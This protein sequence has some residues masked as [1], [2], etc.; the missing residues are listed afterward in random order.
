MKAIQFS[1]TTQQPLLATSFQG[2]PNSDVSY[3]YI[4]GST[5]RGA[6]IG[7]YLK[8]HQISDLDAAHDADEV[9][10][11]FFDP[12]CTRYLNGY[13]S[14]QSGERSLPSLRSWHKEKSIEFC[15][16]DVRPIFDF[17]I[18]SYKE[19]FYDDEIEREAP[20]LI[21]ERYFW[22]EE[23]DEGIY[24]YS[25]RRRINIHTQRNRK[26]GKATKTEG[27]IFRYDALD[28]DQTFR[29]VIL[30]NDED[31]T[32]LEALLK[33]TED[34]WLGGSRSAGYGHTKL[35]DVSIDNGYHEVGLA[36]EERRSYEGGIVITLLSDLILRNEYG[37]PIADWKRVG[38]EIVRSISLEQIP[39]PT[40]AFT[41]RTLVGGFNRKWGLPLPQVPAIA[42]GSVILFKDL[43]LTNEQIQA[44]EEQGLGDRREDGFGRI[45][46]NL[47]AHWKGRE[48]LQVFLPK[49]PHQN[50]EPASLSESSQDLASQMAG[51]L[52]EQK[53]MQQVQ[54]KLSYI[55]LESK[56]ES[57][58]ISNRQLSRLRLVARKALATG[59]TE[60]V[61]KFLDQ[62]TDSSKKKFQNAKIKQ[63][64]N[65]FSSFDFVL[66][67][68]LED[69][70]S[71]ISNPQ[72][73]VVK[74]ANKSCEL[75][76]ELAKKYTLQLIMAVTKKAIK[77]EKKS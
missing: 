66:R 16:S 31:A 7:R 33:K 22:V 50:E 47:Q 23:E 32:T 3:N 24:L 53:L 71:W 63:F 65:S 70:K 11:L 38:E 30:C 75:T 1:L 21:G 42:A 56:K 43:S 72:S 13:L 62:L 10:R 36:A 76:D 6:V 2:D 52:L 29:A 37:Q 60:E 19:D 69:P 34:L 12:D 61:V 40:Q 49:P 25:P 58:N 46:V 67:S 45:A 15:E 39:E 48:A 57:E 5:I 26:R 44:L 9:R 51:R 4:P 41:G 17:S 28:A 77:E 20:K 73:M 8:E 35:R 54:K 64:N 68:W 18:S 59:A 55:S 14:S 74:V 27:G